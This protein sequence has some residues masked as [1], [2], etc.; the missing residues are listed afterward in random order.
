[1]M[2]RCASSPL[3]CSTADDNVVDRAKADDNGVAL[4]GDGGATCVKEQDRSLMASRRAAVRPNDAEGAY[5]DS[6][7]PQWASATSVPS[8]VRMATGPSGRTSTRTAGS[9][10]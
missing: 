3:H 4:R 8:I 7:D 5:A 6:A 2:T 9:Q 1:M 10:R